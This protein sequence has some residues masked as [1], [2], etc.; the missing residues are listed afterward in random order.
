MLLGFGTHFEVWSYE[1]ATAAR[2]L[3]HF[4]HTKAAEAAK[5]LMKLLKSHNIT[6]K[7]VTVPQD[8]IYWCVCVCVRIVAACCQ[9]CDV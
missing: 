6:V 7:V 1:C 5:Y 8:A 4:L 3:G 2:G 9:C